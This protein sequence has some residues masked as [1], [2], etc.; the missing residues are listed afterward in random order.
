MVEVAIAWR[1]RLVHNFANNDIS[2]KIRISLMEKENIIEGNYS[3]LN[4][5]SLLD[6]FDQE[7]TPRFK[8]ITSL[9]RAVHNFVYEVDSVLLSKLDLKKYLE[10]IL[11]YHLK[12]NYDA[13]SSQRPNSRAG[14][15][16][17][18]DTFKQLKQIFQNYGLT[19]HLEEEDLK[20]DLEYIEKLSELSPSE[21][22]SRY[23][24]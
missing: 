8:E 4:I 11:I 19:S 18:K 5:S 13:N 1:N 7:K 24:D 17:S 16:W 23:I 15:I 12:K 2:E 20:I 9:V 21:A 3:G 14:S 22:I 10:E 6:R